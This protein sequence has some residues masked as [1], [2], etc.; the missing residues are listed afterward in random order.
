MLLDVRDK[1]EQWCFETNRELFAR[2][3]LHLLDPKAPHMRDYAIATRSLCV[4][5]VTPL[6]DEVL[7]WLEPNA[8]TLGWNAGNEF[9]FVAQ[10]TRFAHFT[11]ASNWIMNLP[12]MSCLR[13]GHEIPW[14]ALQVNRKSQTVPLAL[15]WPEDTHFTSFVLSDGD[16]VQWFLGGFANHANAYWR[17]ENRGAFPFGWTM[18]VT[19]LSQAGPS[20]L[21]HLSRTGSVNDQAVTFPSG[22][23]YP[24]F[25]AHAR[26]ADMDWYA[27]RV[28]MFAERLDK[29]GVRVI[30]NIAENWQ[31]DGARHAY[32]TFARQVPNIVGILAMQYHP[33][34]AGRGEILWTEDERGR[35]IPVVSPRF[36]IWSNLS[37]LE[38]NGPPALVAE[39]I[40]AQPHQGLAGCDA[41]FDWTVVHAWS[42]FKKADT[43]TD[44]LAEEMEQTRPLPRDGVVRNAYEPTY[45]CVQ[46]LAPHVRVVLPE[47]LLWRIR[48]QLRTRETLAA[49][50][51]DLM[52]HTDAPSWQR[53]VLRGYRER[54]AKSEIKTSAQCRAAFHWLQ[55]IYWAKILDAND[56]PD[57]LG[58]RDR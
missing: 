18:P 52:D 49:L 44:K 16:N 43:S 19:H 8:P 4:F 25:Y 45:W 26:G 53:Q 3:H 24:D 36:S 30:I 6:V 58:E 48:L 10:L 40:N 42:R 47:E 34:N 12:V 33:Y 35:P 11:T 46:R 13:A 21:H 28:A 27:G 57:D 51:E 20:L 37:H 56:L 39:M 5:G 41:Y 55:D 32:Q 15:D 23:Y 14:E 17:A 50:A 1:D 31:S 54:L 2:S 9:K 29:L 22:Y 7:A 38:N